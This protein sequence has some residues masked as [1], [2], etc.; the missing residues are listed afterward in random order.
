M[1]DAEWRNGC[2]RRRSTEGVVDCRGVSEAGSLCSSELAAGQQMH[3]I[4]QGKDQYRRA[5]HLHELQ[6]AELMKCWEEAVPIMK[7]LAFTCDMCT[8]R[9]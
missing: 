3:L 2:F 1:V 8:S 9:A 6:S 5:A 7:I 4:V